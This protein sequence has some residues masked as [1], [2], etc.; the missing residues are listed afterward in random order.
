MADLW[1]EYDHAPFVT[2][3][4]EAGPHVVRY[5]DNAQAIADIEELLGSGGT[6]EAESSHDRTQ[7]T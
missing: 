2:A 5:Q 3:A 4:R 6:V 7:A 1:R